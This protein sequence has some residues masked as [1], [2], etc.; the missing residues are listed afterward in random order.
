MSK[1]RVATMVCS[2]LLLA[3]VSTAVPL[4]L[5]GGTAY[6]HGTTYKVN[7]F[8]NYSNDVE[9]TAM[10]KFT[11]SATTGAYTLTI[12]SVNIVDSTGSSFITAGLNTSNALIVQFDGD[13]DIDVPMTQNTK[14][15]L[16]QVDATDSMYAPFCGSGQSIEVFDAL[17]IG[18]KFL[19]YA[20]L[21]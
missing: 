13:Q 16:F 9:T 18:E 4:L 3:A 2:V 6:A 1:L 11:C 19:F 12:P 15:G 10:A 17:T 5:T 7:K 21:R 20:T 8:A 14:N